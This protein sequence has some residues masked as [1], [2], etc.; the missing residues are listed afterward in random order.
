MKRANFLA[1]VAV[2]S[3]LT[4]SGGLAIDTA[5][6]DAAAA[7][8]PQARG[9]PA[10]EISETSDGGCLPGSRDS[11]PWC[12]D[13]EILLTVEGTSLHV[14]HCNAVYN[15][16]CDDIVISLEVEE[17]ILRLTEEEI[18]GDPCDC[19][20]CY[21]VEATIVNLPPGTYTVIFGWLDWNTSAWTYYEENIV[22]EPPCGDLDGDGSVGLADF[23]TFAVCFG[24]NGPTAECRFEEFVCSDLDGDG[25][26]GLTDFSTFSVLFGLPVANTLPDCTGSD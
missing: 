26:V 12:G 17:S 5:G 16:C 25:S 7:P 6:P 9:L 2:V 14:L 19:M 24:L 22:I 13:D 4:A 8:Q 18:L 20:C 1:G 10:P 11:Y 15:C 23:A 3:L 21:D